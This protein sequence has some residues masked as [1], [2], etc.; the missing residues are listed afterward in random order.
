MPIAS[1]QFL[2]VP[3]IVRALQFPGVY[4][5]SLVPLSS[6]E[7]QSDFEIWQL[8]E[9]YRIPLSLALGGMIDLMTHVSWYWDK[10]Y[11]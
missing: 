6:G 11:H 4:L 5:F 10:I 2:A 3:N 7:L 1:D 9:D 8:T